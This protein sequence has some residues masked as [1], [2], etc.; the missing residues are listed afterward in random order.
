MQAVSYYLV[1]ADKAERLAELISDERAKT[2]LLKMAEDYRDIARD[3]ESGA[4]EI[5]HRD[6]LP[7]LDHPR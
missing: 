1:Q 6:R 5:R 2:D 4:V 3:L 7:Q